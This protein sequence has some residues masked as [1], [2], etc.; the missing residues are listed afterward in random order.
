MEKSGTSRVKA[1]MIAPCSSVSRSSFWNFSL[2]ANER[3]TASRAKYREIR[4]ARLAPS[5]A[6]LITRTTPS[7]DPKRAPAVTVRAEPGMAA[8]TPMA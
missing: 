3:V 6:A 8:T 5:V 7:T 4:N 2:A 1:T